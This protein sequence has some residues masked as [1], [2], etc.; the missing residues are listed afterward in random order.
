MKLGAIMTPMR[1]LAV[2]AAVLVL[3]PVLSVAMPP[4]LDYPNHLVRYWLLSGGA[5]RLPMSGMFVA[6]WGHSATNIATDVVG[7]GLD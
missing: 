4:L 2:A 5:A 1:C 6:D 3:V 7:A